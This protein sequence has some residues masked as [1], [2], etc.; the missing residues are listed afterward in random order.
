MPNHIKTAAAT[1]NKNRARGGNNK[2]QE[3]REIRRAP[4]LTCRTVTHQEK[5]KQKK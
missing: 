4:I 2:I 3:I 5:D 1:A